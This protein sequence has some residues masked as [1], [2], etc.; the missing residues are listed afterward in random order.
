MNRAGGAETPEKEEILRQ[1]AGDKRI[2]T[3][4][5]TGAFWGAGCGD[6]LVYAGLEGWLF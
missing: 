3:W 6:F 2:E 5:A 4:R 1:M